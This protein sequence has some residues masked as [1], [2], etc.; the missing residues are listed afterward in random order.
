MDPCLDREQW[1]ITVTAIRDSADVVGKP[2]PRQRFPDWLIVAMFCWAA[3]HDKS[4]SW[5]CYRFHYNTLFRPRGPLPG[6]SQFTRRIKSESCQAILERVNQ[7]LAAS[8]VPSPLG[9]IDAKP[10]TVSTVS[11]DPDAKRG[12]ITGGF[13]KG[14]KLHAYVTE[15]RRIAVWVVVPLNADEKTVARELIVP[16]LPPT[17]DPRSDLILADSNYDAAPVYNLVSQNSR[18]ERALLT[19]IRGKQFVGP[20]G[21][22]KDTLTAMG[23]HRREAI[24]IWETSPD[25]AEHLMHQRNNIEGTFSVLAMCLNMHALPGFVRRLPRVTRWIT[26]KIILYH[27]KLLAQERAGVA[28]AA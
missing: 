22:S 25:L 7:R 18:G 23:P 1:Q 24:K 14:Y 12:H 10:L 28:A 26:A 19:P 21:R 9:F 3:W 6:I 17:V 11:K 2:L 13:A 16:N 20:Q 27:A 4:L 5:A 15:T 8:G